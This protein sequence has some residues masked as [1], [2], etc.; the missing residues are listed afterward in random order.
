MLLYYYVIV[1][2]INKSINSPR[3][4]MLNIYYLFEAPV[5]E[6]LTSLVFIICFSPLK[7]W[8]ALQLCLDEI[9]F[10]IDSLMSLLFQI[11]D[12]KFE[13]MG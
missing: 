5:K 8:I 9:L 7:S 11:L 13:A 10:L 3:M 6:L 1:L 2:L 4:L 12:T